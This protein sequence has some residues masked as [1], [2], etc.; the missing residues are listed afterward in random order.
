[1]KS[2]DQAIYDELFKLCQKLGYKVFEDRPMKEVGYPFIDFEDTEVNPIP[3]KSNIKGN[4]N[5]T[6]NVWGLAKK[7]A[8]VSYIAEQIFN[9]AN[10]INQAYDVPV[11]LRLMA[12]QRRILTDNSTNT[13]LKRAIVELEFSLL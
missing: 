1:M 5:I 9:Q 2:V 8:E 7:R 11:S 6:I 4:V 12:C 3:N 10:E 13:T